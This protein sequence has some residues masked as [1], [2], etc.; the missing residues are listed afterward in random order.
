MKMLCVLKVNRDLKQILSTAKCT[1][2]TPIDKHLFKGG[3]IRY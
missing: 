2:E 3:L 1:L